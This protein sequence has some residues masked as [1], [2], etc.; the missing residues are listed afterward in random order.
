M[1]ALLAVILLSQA[2]PAQPPDEESRAAIE[3]MNRARVTFE[4]GDYAQASKLLAAL[5]EAGRFEA[6]QM[7]AQAYRVL[8]VSL[9]YQG[10]KGGACDAFLEDLYINPNSQ[11]TPV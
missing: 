3:A 9:F 8:G 5:L 2:Q 10:G 6:L 1:I 7:R 4:Y 11:R